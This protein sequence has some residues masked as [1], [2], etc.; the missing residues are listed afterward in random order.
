M[1][2]LLKP[3]F[4][5]PISFARWFSQ[6]WNAFW[7]TPADPTTLG[8]IRLLTGLMVVYNHA[9]W[10]LA[11]EDFFGPHSW[12]SPDL[13]AFIHKYQFQYSYSFWFLVPAGWLWPAYLAAMTVLVLFAI[14]LWT[15]ITSILALAV[16]ISFVHRVPE[17]LFGLD[18][19]YVILTLYL[20]IGPSGAAL[21]LDR[22]LARRRRGGEPTPPA[23]S[24]MANL[25]QRLIQVHMCIVYFFSGITKLL[26]LPWWTGEAMWLALANLDYAAADTTWLAWHPW[27]LNFLTH[28]TVLWELSFGVFVWLPRWRPLVLAGAVFLHAGIGA[29]L[30]LWTF[31]LIMLVG[32]ASFVPGEAVRRFLHALL[33]RAADGNTAAIVAPAGRTDA[34]VRRQRR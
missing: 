2:E 16:E 4:L 6:A 26:G 19:I 12:I 33:P 18:K 14:G 24:S 30:G 3:L 9:V 7:F 29:F 31:S 5:Y 13:I 15:R 17:A 22:V 23:P 11:L 20:A 10:G 28:F 32:C 25:A 21:S 27:V 1:R 8:L 34:E